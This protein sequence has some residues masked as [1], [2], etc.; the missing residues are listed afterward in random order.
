M[1]KLKKCLSAILAGMLSVSLLG[2]LAVNAETV[3]TEK[4]YIYIIRI[5]RNERGRIFCTRF[6]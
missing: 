5:I 2:S 1:K 6:F 4:K 3:D